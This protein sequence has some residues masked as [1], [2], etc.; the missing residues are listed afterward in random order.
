MAE[1]TRTY[2][3]TGELQREV[4]ILN[5]KRNGEQKWYDSN[6]QLESICSYIDDK[7]NGEYKNSFGKMDNY[8]KYVHLLMVIFTVYIK[9]T[10][11]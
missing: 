9:N 10:T 11:V 5:G 8:S 2:Y 3:S 7:L 4:F 6:G 1:V